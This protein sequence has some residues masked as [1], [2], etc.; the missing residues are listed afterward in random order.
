MSHINGRINLFG[1]EYSFIFEDNVLKV[2][3]DISNKLVEPLTSGKLDTAVLRGSFENESKF[4]TFYVGENNYF[5]G[6]TAKYYVFTTFQI[7]VIFYVIHDRPFN[8]MNFTKIKLKME[9]EK[10]RKWLGFYESHN[11][12]AKTIEQDYISD[13][14]QYCDLSCK[15]KSTFSFKGIEILVEPFLNISTDFSS[16]SVH[17]SLCFSYQ[18]NKIDFDYINDLFTIIHKMLKFIFYRQNVEFGNVQLLIEHEIS[19]K[20]MFEKIGQIIVPISND[21]EMENSDLNKTNDMG[22]IQWNEIYN[23]LPNLVKLISDDELYLFSLP[24]RKKELRYITINSASL[25]ASSFEFE[26]SKLF[27]ENLFQDI[28]DRE[29]IKK[30]ID[31][32]IFLFENENQKDLITKTTSFLFNPTLVMKNKKALQ[33]FVLFIK[34][35]CDKF[36]YS[37]YVDEVSKEFVDIRNRIDHGNKNLKISPTTAN[38]FYIERVLVFCMQL[39]RIGF[40][41]D[42]ILNAIK[43]VFELF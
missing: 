35:I 23:F 43:T 22:Y 42:S 26:F 29:K 33:S 27:K 36:G 16:S 12:D 10:F 1:E 30:I 14:V 19:G 13:S 18:S 25:I 24:I 5:T 32:N 31:D 37:N 41:D 15:N 4:I 39:R 38:A 9:N 7:P 20:N 6:L 28:E 2:N 40:Q 8:A 21:Y 3:I 17:S 34:P 11:F